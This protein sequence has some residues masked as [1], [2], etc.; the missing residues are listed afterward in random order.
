MISSSIHINAAFPKHRIGHRM[1]YD[2]VNDRIIM[3]GGSTA[4]GFQGWVF[5]TWA[6]DYNTNEWTKLIT[7]NSP[8]GSNA[9]IAYDSESDKIISFGGSHADHVVSNQTWIYDYTEN[10]WTQVTPSNVPRIRESSKMVYDSES[11][12]VIMLGGSLSEDSNLDGFKLRFNDTWAY[13]Y[14][15]NTWTNITSA[16]YPLNYQFDC[17]AY[18]SESDL[19][20]VFGGSTES[21]P[22]LD[23]TGGR[24]HG[25]TW[26]FD[27]NTNTWDN[28]TPS[29]SPVPRFGAN[30]VYDSEHDLMILVGGYTHLL[31]TEIDHETWSFDYNTLSWTELNL[32][33]GLEIRAH[34][35]AYDSESEKIV[36]FGGNTGDD[37]FNFFDDT[38]VGD[39][40]FNNWTK[41]PYPEDTTDTNSFIIPTLI[42]LSIIA[43][44][45]VKRR[46]NR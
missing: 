38:W 46:R 29:V 26:S 42:S 19:V 6:Y 22:Y 9:R 20:I 4:T 39:L 23:P 16:T 18:D 7:D 17:I 25:E 3:Y 33:G 14:N 2:S 21:D 31:R 28:I 5:D 32:D 13:D 27:Y 36:I 34:S 45:L 8:Y 1:I 11:D 44:V 12:V 35:M 30:M 40:D 37:P 41:M 15:A 24:Y 43:I 10:T